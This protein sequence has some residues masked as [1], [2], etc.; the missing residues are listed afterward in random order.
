MSKTRVS[1]YE[2]EQNESADN[3]D[4]F[5]FMKKGIDFTL[6]IQNKYS[7]PAFAI[8]TPIYD[9]IIITYK[10]VYSHA[11]KA[12]MPDTAYTIIKTVI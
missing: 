11:G 4:Q 8:V 12:N 5:L 2:N 10:K 7:G 9:S 6:R 1:P 3:A